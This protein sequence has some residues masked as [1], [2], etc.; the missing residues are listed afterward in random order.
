MSNEHTTGYEE[1]AYCTTIGVVDGM[2]WFEDGTS[3]DAVTVELIAAA[4]DLLAAACR[5]LDYFDSP[6]DHPDCTQADVLIRLRE[7]VEDAT[8]EEA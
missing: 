2:A 3:V 6:D 7:V 1:E 5:L 4:P 8:K